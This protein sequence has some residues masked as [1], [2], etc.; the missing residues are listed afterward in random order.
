MNEQQLTDTV[1]AMYEECDRNVDI[2]DGTEI[3]GR[4]Y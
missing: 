4:D 2:C 1:L 3:L